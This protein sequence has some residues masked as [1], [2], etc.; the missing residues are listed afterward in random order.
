MMKFLFSLSGRRKVQTLSNLYV[1][2]FSRFVRFSSDSKAGA[3][4]ALDLTKIDRLC[5]TIR[6]LKRL[7]MPEMLESKCHTIDIGSV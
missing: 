3:C 5:I 7:Y 6:Y 2:S 4:H 1:A